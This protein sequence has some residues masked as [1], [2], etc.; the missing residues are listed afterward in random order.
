MPGP[1]ESAGT[2]L[3]LQE[4][5]GTKSE[6]PGGRQTRSRTDALLWKEETNVGK[7]KT[8][9]DMPKG[10]LELPW[11]D[12]QDQGIQG[13]RFGEF[14][15]FPALEGRMNTTSEYQKGPRRDLQMT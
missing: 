5:S 10:F 3:G 8:S 2:K 13:F 6:S 11:D 7:P 12:P 1:E 14:E 4:L 9:E 15:K